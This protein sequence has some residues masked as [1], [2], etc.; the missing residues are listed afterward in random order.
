MGPLASNMFDS[1]L[2]AA[3]AVML[4]AIYTRSVFAT[5]KRII[6]S[7]FLSAH[8]HLAALAVLTGAAALSLM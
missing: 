3:N 8:F 6:A 1:V 4:L 7:A 2:H 5:H